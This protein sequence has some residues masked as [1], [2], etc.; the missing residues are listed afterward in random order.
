MKSITREDILKSF[1]KGFELAKGDIEKFYASSLLKDVNFKNPEGE[2]ALH[3][4]CREN[5]IR[6]VRFFLEQGVDSSELSSEGKF[7]IELTNNPDIKNAIRESKKWQNLKEETASYIRLA[8]LKYV[9][10]DEIFS[11]SK[12]WQDHIKKVRNFIYKSKNQQNFKFIYE[13]FIQDNESNPTTITTDNNNLL[14]KNTEET[15]NQNHKKLEIEENIQTSESKNEKQNNSPKVSLVDL[16]H[17]EQKKRS[18]EE[19]ARK[20]ELRLRNIETNLMRKEDN[21]AQ[22]KR[23]EER[24]QQNKEKKDTK[25][26]EITQQKKSNENLVN[27]NEEEILKK[28]VE[29]SN[30][31]RKEIEKAKRQ[32]IDQLNSFIS[33]IYTELGIERKRS[34]SFEEYQQEDNIIKLFGVLMNIAVLSKKY[35]TVEK[36]LNHHFKD[37]FVDYSD[38]KDGKTCLIKA[39]ENSC[40]GI[41]QLLIEKGADVK[42]FD[43]NGNSALHYC[44]INKDKENQEKKPSS[45]ESII[46][47]DIQSSQI[48]KM[49]ID[50][51]A[52]DWNFLSAHNSNQ[53]SAFTLCC[54]AYGNSKV[55]ESLL[56]TKAYRYNSDQMPI[57]FLKTMVQTYKNH[58]EN[59][60]SQ[61]NKEAMRVLV[62][63]SVEDFKSNKA[64]SKVANNAQQ[65]S[66]KTNNK[67]HE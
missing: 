35:D 59:H 52:N 61:V 38:E 43:K 21:L 42:I 39:C 6:A 37:K 33:E 3:I 20:E 54:K 55:L 67:S 27:N 66:G 62:T 40:F 2:T 24:K 11:N 26:P 4:A 34:I 49:I 30:K 53:M 31:E 9:N 16:W 17:Q 23:E 12:E 5:K 56:E 8:G 60:D 32:E 41:A 51:T 10:F 28:A 19:I 48:A 25:K 22:A 47:Q 1:I 7:A 57:S 45:Q 64:I 58:P 29:E 15:E 65:L 63:K 18:K 44:A 14:T 46:N 36:L 13:A 50:Q